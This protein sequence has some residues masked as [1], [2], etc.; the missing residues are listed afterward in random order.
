M[1]GDKDLAPARRVAPGDNDSPA[2]RVA[3]AAAASGDTCAVP[4]ADGNGDGDG[5][6]NGNS[7]GD[8]DGDPERLPDA[9]RPRAACGG[10][11]GDD[12][13]DAAAESPHG[14]GDGALRSTCSLAAGAC[15]DDGGN[16][17]GGDVDARATASGG[18]VATAA[19]SDARRGTAAGSTHALVA[20]AAAVPTAAAAFDVVSHEHVP[21]E[22]GGCAASLPTRTFPFALAFEAR[23]PAVPGSA[24]CHGDSDVSDAASL[25][26]RNSPGSMRVHSLSARCTTLPRPACPPSPP[27]LPAAAA[28]RLAAVP[29]FAGIAP[30]TPSPP[31]PSSTSAEL[32]WSASTMAPAPTFA[33]WSTR[34]SELRPRTVSPAPPATPMLLALPAAPGV[35]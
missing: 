28:S 13:G 6:G 29:S 24:S 25:P 3:E 10:G 16:G 33:S 31:P 32:S 9:A 18:T 15:A 19:V 8:A 4:D 34:C 17:I 23:A 12:A 21:F 26:A 20:T 22:T 14:D 7:D 2:G 35:S 5:D 1:R 11:D 30:P 27:P